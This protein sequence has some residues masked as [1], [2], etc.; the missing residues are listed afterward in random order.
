[1][2]LHTFQKSQ[3]FCQDLV[4]PGSLAGLGNPPLQNLYVRKNQLEVYGLNI[5][6]RVNAAVHMDNVAV[7]K[8]AHN[9]D[10]SIYLTD[11]RQKLV[12]QSFAFARPFHKPCNVHKF[13]DSRGHFLG[14]I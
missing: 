4:H 5:T 8:A 2:C 9:M 3:L 11:V 7:F 12:T 10:D 6:Y 14:F 13:Y 1:M